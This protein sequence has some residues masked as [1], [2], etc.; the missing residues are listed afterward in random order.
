MSSNYSGQ[1]P[2]EYLNHIAKRIDSFAGKELNRYDGEIE[3]ELEPGK[4]RLKT[5]REIKALLEIEEL[6]KQQNSE[7]YFQVLETYNCADL[8]P[9]MA[10]AESSLSR[11]EFFDASVELSEQDYLELENGN[12]ELTEK[13]EKALEGLEII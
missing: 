9:E 10:A 2:Q 13:G 8:T 12:A 1:S 11:S 6:A 3:T 7:L 4:D 5:D